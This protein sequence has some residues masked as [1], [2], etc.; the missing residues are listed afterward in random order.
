MLQNRNRIFC[1]VSG[2]VIASV[3]LIGCND[4]GPWLIKMNPV[5]INLLLAGFFAH[6]LFGQRLPLITR[7][8][9]SMGDEVDTATRHYTR[10]LTLVWAVFFVL[11]A[12]ESAVL[13]MW[14]SLEIWSLMTGFVNY[15]FVGLFFIIEFLVRRRLLPR[16]TRK[17]F[18]YFIFSLARSY[19]RKLCAN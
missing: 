3:V 17:G 5:L 12:L 16:Q 4:Q 19:Y 14:A 7:I 1:A 11:L 9:Q 18:G 15:I 6:T 8:A 10:S 2:L 13:A